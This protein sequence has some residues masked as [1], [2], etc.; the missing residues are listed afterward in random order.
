MFSGLVVEFLEHC[1]QSE[2][3]K[4]MQDS[5]TCGEPVDFLEVEFEI[6]RVHEWRYACK[7]N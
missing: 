5:Y 6:L 3:W 7:L 1:S 4:S 2:V